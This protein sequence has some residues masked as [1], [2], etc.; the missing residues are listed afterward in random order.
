MFAY[1]RLGSLLGWVLS[2]GLLS[3]CQ[4]DT[5]KNSV[6]DNSIAKPSENMDSSIPADAPTYLVGTMGSY[7]PF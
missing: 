1:R 4:A 5:D 2:V 3:A 7:A 6:A